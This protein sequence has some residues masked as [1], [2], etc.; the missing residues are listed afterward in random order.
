MNILDRIAA[1]FEESLQVKEATWKENATAIERAVE[2]LVRC[3][4][5]GGKVLIFGNGG[6][7]AD[8]QHFAAELVGRFE[9]E[10]EALAAVALTTDTSI[11]T[12]LGNDYGFDT[13]FAR[14]IEALGRPQDAAVGLSTSG[15]SPNVLKGL[16]TAKRLGLFTLGLT[17]SFTGAFDEV[18]DIVLSVPSMD[19]PRI[20]ESHICLIHCLCELIE[21]AFVTQ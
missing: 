21:D 9:Q 7:A 11:L 14:Q 4:K 19:T 17:G 6:S 16:D 20:Q 13:V 12:A 8:A 2:Q 10:R 1:V 15:K 5:Q 3:L 18:C